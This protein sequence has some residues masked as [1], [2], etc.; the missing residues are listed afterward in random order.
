MKSAIRASLVLGIRESEQLTK[1]RSENEA[2][3][4]SKRQLNQELA[5]EEREGLV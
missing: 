5:E 2:E 4:K 3:E 1:D